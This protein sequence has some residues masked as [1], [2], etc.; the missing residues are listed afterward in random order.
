MHVSVG[1]LDI[2][3]VGWTKNFDGS[4]GYDD[5]YLGFLFRYLKVLRLHA[6][7]HDAAGA[8]GAHSGKSPGN[9]YTI[10]R[11]TNS[12]LLGHLTGLFFCPNVKL[13]LP[14]IFNAVDY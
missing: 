10:G 1:T 12:F 11:V 3:C 4:I 5:S 6:I 7:L 9:Y 13:F 2:L 14:S 8:A